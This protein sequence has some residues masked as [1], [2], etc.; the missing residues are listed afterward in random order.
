M[1]DE[2]WVIYDAVDNNVEYVNTEEEA[3]KRLKELVADSKDYNSYGV[4]WL[5]NV[6]YCFIAK[7]THKLKEKHY[8]NFFDYEIV[9]EK[10]K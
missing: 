3:V 4:E 10:I 6:E 1:K 7:I 8:N 9:K 2:K 5:E